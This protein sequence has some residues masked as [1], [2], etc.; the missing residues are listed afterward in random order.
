MNEMMAGHTPPSFAA[1]ARTDLGVDIAPRGGRGGLC[2]ARRRCPLDSAADPAEGPARA[3]MAE[4]GYTNSFTPQ[5]APIGP[6]DRQWE[7]ARRIVVAGR[8]GAASGRDG[9]RAG[10]GRWALINRGPSQK[11]R[12]ITSC[13]SAFPPRH[14]R[15]AVE[16]LIG[17]YH[18]AGRPRGERAE[19]LRDALDFPAAQMLAEGAVI[20]SSADDRCRRRGNSAAGA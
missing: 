7:A 1:W 6:A 2:L 10:R 11:H 5:E 20:A 19:N 12:G 9:P 14:P 15:R 13:N 3:L 17:Y 8:L 4:A 18:P 16:A